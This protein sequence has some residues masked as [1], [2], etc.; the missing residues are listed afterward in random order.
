MEHDNMEMDKS[1]KPGLL[2]NKLIWLIV[3]A[4][5]FVIIAFI[6]PTPQSLIELVEK[7]KIA[8]RMIEWHVAHDVAQ[9]AWKAK[10]VLAMI[11]MAVIY[12]ATEALPIGLVGIL[13]PM[14]AYFFKLLPMKMIG[15][16]FAGDAPLF[17]L[18]VLAMGVTVIGVGLHKRLATWISRVDQRVCAA[19]CRFVCFHVRPGILYI[20]PCHGGLYGAGD[21]G[22][23]H[24][25]GFSQQ[26]S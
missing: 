19:H 15:Q 17:L 23:L 26:Q 3:G 24:G 8:E 20:R 9:A 4:A 12:F 21:G 1:K 25:S 2:S 6:I 10:L 5:C 14:F 18:G 13:M 16:T 7:Q 11:P 22:R